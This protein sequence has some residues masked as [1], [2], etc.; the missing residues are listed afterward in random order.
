[1]KVIALIFSLSLLP[2]A[3]NAQFLLSE[4]VADNVEGIRDEDGTRQDWIEIQNTATVPASL[5]GWFLTDSSSQLRKWAFPNMFLQ[6]GEFLVAFASNK[7]RRNALKPLHTNFKLDAGGEYLALTRAEPGGSTT[8]IQSLNPYPPQ[9]VDSSYGHVA[10]SYSYLTQTTPGAANSGAAT[11][12]G[13][14]ISGTTKN[15]VPPLGGIG[16]LPI[17]VS[18][19][20][21]P[22][23]NPTSH[24]HL[25]Y[26]V[27]WGA[28]T[29]APMRDDGVLPDLKAGDKIFT[30]QIPT[31]G[32]TSGQMIRWRVIASDSAGNVST[33]PQFVDWDGDLEQDTDQYF[34]TLIVDSGYATSLPV[35]HWFIQ[36]PT[37][38]ETLTEGTHCSLFFLGRFYD[39]VEVTKHGQSTAFFAKKSYNLNF[40][41]S[42][43]FIWKLGE[44]A[45]PSV[46][47]L[48]NFGDKSKLR[49][50]LAW[51]AWQ[52]CKHLASHFSQILHVRRATGGEEMQFF[53]IYDM[54]E[55][56][57]EEFL[58]RCGLDKNGAL[59]KMGYSLITWPPTTIPATEKK[60][61]KWEGN[62]DLQQLQ[63]GLTQ[64]GDGTFSQKQKRRQFLY[65][66]VGI[67]A[68]I[69]MCVV[70]SLISNLDWG[71][72]NYYMYRDTDGTK[73]WQMLPWDQDLT[74]G[75][76]WWFEKGGH[77]DDEIGSQGYFPSGANYNPMWELIAGDSASQRIPELHEMMLTRTRTLMDQMF[78]SESAT[79]GLW[80][81][82]VTTLIDQID[83]PGAALTD[84]DRELQKW[85]FWEDGVAT[86]QFSGDLDA[87]V[88]PHGARLQAMRILNF[89]PNPPQTSRISGHPTGDTTLPFLVG[90]RAFLYQNSQAFGIPSSPMAAPALAIEQIEFNPASGNQDEEFFVIRNDSGA[91]V[92]LSGWSLSGGVDHV[93]P[94]GTV[95]PSFTGLENVGFL[96]IA[97]SP[98]DFRSR[99]SGPSGGQFRFVV[100]PYSG[101]L[102][103][104]GESILLKKP[105][106]TV[107]ASGSWTPSPTSA[108]NQLR[109]SEINYAPQAPSSTESAQIANVSASDFEYIELQNI[110]ETPLDLAGTRF[111][112][113]V[114]F[115]FSA[116]F[117]LAAGARVLIVSNRNAFVS[118]YGSGATIAGEYIGYLDNDGDTIRIID[119][120]GEEV[121]EFR[122]EPDWFPSSDGHGYS[123]VTRSS[124]PNWSDYG[125]PTQPAPRSW[126]LSLAGGTPGSGD[127]DFSIDFDGWRFD[128]WPVQDVLVPGSLITPT[129][130]NDGDS[131]NNFA[132]YC[133]GR[134]PK[135]SDASSLCVVELVNVNGVDYPG[136]RFTRRHLAADVTW[137]IQ[138]SSDLS[139]WTTATI[140]VSTS[141]VTDG[142]ESVVYRAATADT[143]RY[144]R[145]VAARP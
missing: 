108:Q 106:G 68:L 2:L 21:R 28:E 62:E 132:E 129:E 24:V 42:N 4:F 113:G 7:N 71:H 125:S 20:V 57:N 5:A 95:I 98:A 56:G 110:G 53:A 59:Y 122:Y 117:S 78:L 145:V 8:V 114:E 60:T 111:T 118:R 126:T 39:F 140:P 3:V 97:K 17:T 70:N 123:L 67:P 131:M 65:D 86:P 35:L 52:D 51:T 55:D 30:A 61:R 121:L 116:G 109:V 124:S 34:G 133:F 58:E 22:R 103:A 66:N 112:K 31:S 23:L 87:A 85:G 75:H 104:R 27:M 9:G 81:T 74:F 19:N 94:A 26:V 138:E 46:N 79:T 83:P 142:T 101:S 40:N 130:D 137:F 134:N 128:H 10:A 99:P 76:S 15:P 93:L 107:V 141:A 136:I 89:N 12:I 14:H 115:A 90:R 102:S 45:I 29:T 64:Q 13:P 84:A 25:A 82:R 127:V 41:K 18:A 100:G 91:A 73:E 32:L 54:V 69:N 80:D 92:D 6:P 1:M 11:L 50:T 120:A 63:A 47:L 77:F 144:F 139:R 43:R 44:K 33:D 48:S 36:D 49:N 72:N 38:A 119:N 96:H 135:L 105:D 16:S 37:L 143:P 88:H